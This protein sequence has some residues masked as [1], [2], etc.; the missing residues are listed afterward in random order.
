MERDTPAPAR[1]PLP[2]TTDPD[3]LLTRP[4]VIRLVLAVLVSLGTPGAG[5][6]LIGRWRRGLIWFAAQ[7]M[8]AMAWVYLPGALTLPILVAFL[9]LRLAPCVDVLVLGL[10]LNVVPRP[11]KALGMVL[12]YMA[13]GFM[14]QG[15]VRS[16]VVEMFK[17]PTGALMPT[18]QIGDHVLAEKL[19]HGLREPARGEVVVFEKPHDPER[20]TFVKRIVAL[21]GDTV[22]VRCGVLHVDGQ[23]VAQELVA[24]AY[25][26]WDQDFYAGWTRKLGSRYRETL[27]GRSYE[28]LFLP[29]RPA[30]QQAG[31][32]GAMDLDVN[33]FPHRHRP[34][35]PEL[36]G[37][38]GGRFERAGAG[39]AADPCAPK[40]HYV[41][42][43]GHVFV[44]GDN[45]D[46]SSD[47]R[48]WGPVPVDSIKGKFKTIWWSS[49]EQEG[50]R[51]DRIGTSVQ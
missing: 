13:V 33:D 24:A 4:S 3:A 15:L 17:I 50:I 27:D 29:A 14:L 21:G 2:A 30:L 39:D 34:R 8:T 6:V 19:V 35:F 10:R 20:R 28:V 44:L 31:S 16:Q 9:G 7:L 32:E 47:S 43:E 18:L 41:V 22:E 23:A 26:H 1:K 48:V 12:G 40:M 49:S 25:E 11:G 5:H 36:D 37:A 46:F 51:W 38:A 42:P 45:R